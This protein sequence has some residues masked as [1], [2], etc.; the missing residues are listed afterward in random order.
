[1][2]KPYANDP[3]AIYLS[4]RI[5]ELAHRKSQLEIATQAGF[6]NPNMMTHLKQGKNKIPLDR[7]PAL[8]EALECDPAY[9]MRL[10]LQQAVG[11]TAAAAIVDILRERIS[12]NE[13]AILAEIREVSGDTDPR[14]T[15][16]TR[17][18]LRKVFQR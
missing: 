16:K 13:R 11:V 12:K 15:A 6:A 17:T 9:L 7:V 18:D 2:N 10:A 3:A 5:K 4:Q 1:M 8:A 14:L